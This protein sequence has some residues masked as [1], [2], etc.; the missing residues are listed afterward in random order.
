M[1]LQL[2]GRSQPYDTQLI[3]E[4]MMWFNSILCPSCGVETGYCLLRHWTVI[5][6]VLSCDCGWWTVI[7]SKKHPRVNVAKYRRHWPDGR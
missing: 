2:H 3:V 4:H 5:G 7:P 6:L 1:A